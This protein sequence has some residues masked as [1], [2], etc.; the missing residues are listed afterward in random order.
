MVLY[1]IFPKLLRRHCQNLADGRNTVQQQYGIFDDCRSPTHTRRSITPLENTILKRTGSHIGYLS[2]LWDMVRHLSKT[3]DVREVSDI[4]LFHTCLHA[5][6]NLPKESPNLLSL[7]PLFIALGIQEIDQ[8]MTLRPCLVRLA[9]LL[10]HAAGT[11]HSPEKPHLLLTYIV[12]FHTR[13][14]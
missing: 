1:Y 5:H 3:H 8:A 6:I 14:L 10:F 2:M 12:K 13:V 4:Q 11:V 9:R 7:S